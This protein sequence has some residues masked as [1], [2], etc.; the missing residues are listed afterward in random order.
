MSYTLAQAATAAGVYKSTVLRAIK[1]GKVSG[2]RDEHGQW[3]IEPAQLHRVYP[4]IATATSGNGAMQRDATADASV[5]LAEANQRA[6][7]AEQR[8]VNLREQLDDVRRDRD[9]WRTQAQRLA[10]TDQRARRSWWPWRAAA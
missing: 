9:E 1:A 10:L 5:A 2:N 7:L 6:T 4:P 3:H 8:V